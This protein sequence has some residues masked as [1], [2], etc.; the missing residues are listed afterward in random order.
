MI[1]VIKNIIRG[2]NTCVLATAAHG[3]PHCSLMAYASDRDCR[4]I[5]MVTLK[6]TRKYRNLM[7]NPSVS[8][9]MDNRDE[10]AGSG[11]PEA[12]A[13]TVGGIIG[14]IE[15]PS[16]KRR[17]R[18]KL[19]K[20]HPH[21]LEFLEQEDSEILCVTVDSFLLLKGISDAHFVKVSKD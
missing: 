12:K 18:E 6:S 17:I 1:E 11:G 5:Y 16:K 3:K 4:E 21:L 7:E 14:K 13:L 9:L 10:R 20:R 2:K 15:D 8:L 19:L